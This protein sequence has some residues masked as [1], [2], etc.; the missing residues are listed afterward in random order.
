[1][2]KHFLPVEQQ[3]QVHT[4]GELDTETQHLWL[5]LHGYGQRVE[6][7]ERHFREAVVPGRAFVFPQAPHKFY[8]SGVEGRVGASWMT[9]E[10]R[11]VDIDNQRT[12]LNAVVEWATKK[13]PNAKLHIVGFSQ[14]VATGMRYLGYNA[15]PIASLLAWAGSWPPDL[16]ERST[17]VLKTIRF[18]AWFGSDDPFIGRDKQTFM[19]SHYFD[20]YQFSPEV[21]TYQGGHHFE[22]TSLYSA[23]QRLEQA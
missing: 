20:H 1:M 17:E 7:F 19:R 6:F 11:L 2:S 21:E 12:Y 10:E 22:K 4:L 13:A 5:G 23:I 8:L 15:R 16:D 9:K 3:Q 14:G 18:K